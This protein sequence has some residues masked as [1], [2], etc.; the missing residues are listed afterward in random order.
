MGRMEYLGKRPEES[1][2]NRYAWD[3]LEELNVHL[4]TLTK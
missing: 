2:R 3:D 4:R 1:I